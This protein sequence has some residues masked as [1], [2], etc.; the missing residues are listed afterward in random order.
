MMLTSTTA[1][2]DS[3]LST[4]TQYLSELWQLT[5]SRAILHSKTALHGCL[6]WL[7]TTIS[8]NK[9]KTQCPIL[10]TICPVA[11]V[12]MEMISILSPQQW[13]HITMETSGQRYVT[14]HTYAILWAGSECHN[15]N[16]SYSIIQNSWTYF[17]TVHQNGKLYSKR[18]IH[19]IFLHQSLMSHWLNTNV[20]LLLQASY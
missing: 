12:T 4:L 9:L 6:Q 1:N 17:I 2:F 5:T 16:N 11:Y 10:F 20:L 15:W 7:S 8:H 13:S 3:T 19:T 14:I 18:S